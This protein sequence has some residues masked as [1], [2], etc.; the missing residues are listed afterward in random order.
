M[1]LP[2]LLQSLPRW[3]WLVLAALFAAYLALWGYTVHL[4]AVEQAAGQVV[5]VPV[6]EHDST[7]YANLSEALLHGHFAEPGERFEY[8]HTPGY[9]AFVAAI[10]ALT[11]C[12]YLAVT[13]VQVLLVFAIA[14]MTVALGTVL[15][16]PAVGLWASLLFLV[17]PLVPSIA[18]FILTDILFTFLLTL[19]FLLLITMFPRRP[20]TTVLAVGAIFAA[21]I[22]VRPIGFVAFPI[23]VAPLLVLKAPWKDKVLGALALLLLVTALLSPWMMRNKMHSGVASFSSLVSLDMVYYNLPHFW[24]SKY[25]TP[26]DQGIAQ[27]ERESGVPQ[28]TDAN[29][30]PANWYDL[31]SSPALTHYYLHEVLLTPVSYTIWHLYQSLGFF[32]NAPINPPNQTVSIKALLAAGQWGAFLHAVTTPWWLFAERLLIL[33]GIICATL[34]LW[35][36]R[37][38]AL[39][40]SFGFVILFLAALGGPSA[41]ARYRLPVEPILSICIVV[42]L[43]HLIKLSPM[44]A[45]STK[46]SNKSLLAWSMQTPLLRGIRGALGGRF[47]IRALEAKRATV[48][49]YTEPERAAI[50]DFYRSI[51][52]K[53][54]T[55]LLDVEAVQ[56]Y[57]TVAAT[58]K[59]PGDIAEVGTYRGG[60]ALIMAEASKGKK[61]I[62]TFDTFEGLPQ[63]VDFD[64]KRFSAGQYATPYEEVRAL[65]AKHPF[66]HVYQGFFPSTAGPI[67]DK[68]F[69]FVHLDVDIYQSTKDSLEFFYPRLNSCGAIISHDY[70]NAEGVRRAFD[71]F[72]ADKPEAVIGLS[73]SQCL[74]IKQ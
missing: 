34:G 54:R 13:F 49:Y 2:R 7:S 66:V 41:Q 60:S 15:W 57:Q 61:Q 59:V 70:S 20:T 14:L 40:W 33:C 6:M 19:G 47:L 68:R 10:R 9:P 26:L 69:S 16:S 45:P 50:L 62:H 25:G 8:F 44:A 24:Q 55:L 11:G 39:V 3:Y 32:V 1:K 21:A 67:K 29:G 37:R 23:L 48:V 52:A 42:G 71:E 12:S 36:M 38:S 18:L 53:P 65:L 35:R 72:F 5:V 27:V 63:V 4:A 56:I 30:Y 22:Y 64:D 51:K 73:G 74:V 46:N 43:L 58:A 31:A 28:G 17:N